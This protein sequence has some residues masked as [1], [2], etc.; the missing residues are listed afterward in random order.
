MA[1]RYL[2]KSVQGL[3]DLAETE[4]LIKNTLIHAQIVQ[5]QCFRWEEETP[6]TQ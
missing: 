4:A 6:K 2:I 5:T 3:V 1:Q